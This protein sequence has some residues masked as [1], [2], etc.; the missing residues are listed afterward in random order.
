MCEDAEIRS[1]Y[2]GLTKN[3]DMVEAAM[4]KISV[5]IYTSSMINENGTYVQHLYQYN[6]LPYRCWAIEGGQTIDL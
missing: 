2:A 5:Y 3:D 6:R 4:P 1:Q